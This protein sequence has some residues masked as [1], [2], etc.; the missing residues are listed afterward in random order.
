MVLAFY[1]ADWAPTCSD[2]LENLQEF[3]PNIRATGAELFGVSVDGVWCHQAFAEMHHLEFSL[4]SDFQP[5]GAVARLYGVYD[6]SRGL[7]RR[8]LFVVDRSGIVAWGSV[9]RQVSALGWA[10]F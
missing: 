4:L 6:D 3:L 2:Q 5:K 1:Q 8:S 10:P 7:A 9:T